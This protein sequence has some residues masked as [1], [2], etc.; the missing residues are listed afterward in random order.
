MVGERGIDRGCESP[1]NTKGDDAM[2]LDEIKSAA[3]R[4]SHDDQKRLVLELIEA[5]MPV[6]C[7]DEACLNQIRQFVDDATVRGYRD[8]HMGNI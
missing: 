5:I 8:Q 4:L 6:A 1:I 3:L 7:T 2:T